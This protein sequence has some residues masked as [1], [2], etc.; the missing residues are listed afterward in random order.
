MNTI[1]WGIIGPGSIAMQFTRDLAMSKYK[2]RVTAIVG[3]DSES[4]RKFAKEFDIEEVYTD[5]S[6]LIAGANINVVYVATP[7]PLHY[8]AV[9]EC[10]NHNIPVLCEKPL[11]IN[12]EQCNDLIRTA[13]NKKTFLMEGMW[14]R[15][16]PSIQ[17]LL[18]IVQRG[19]IGKILSIKASISYKA[20]EDDDNRYFDPEKGGGS[21]LDLGIYPVFLSMLLLGKPSV[22]KAIGHLTDKGVDEWASILFKYPDGQHAVLAS[23]LVVE[24]NLPAEI[25]G[26]KGTIRILDPWFEKSPGVEVTTAEEGSIV[27]PSQWEGHGLYFEVD[28]VIE[29]LNKKNI[30]SDQMPHD[31]SFSILNVMDEIR[32]Q[33]NVTYDMYE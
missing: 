18:Q 12:A 9:I 7:H 14:L 10:L 6:Q 25:I 32:K 28:E 31:F 19:T 16:L 4:T 30:C 17:Q 29:Q 15:F 3:N 20:P 11:T 22:I 2:H 23:S 24:T 13:R 5:V 26:E 8:E 33:I 27:Y 21:L 1:K